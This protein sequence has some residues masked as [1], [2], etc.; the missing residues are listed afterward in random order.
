MFEF[1]PGWGWLFLAYTVGTLFGLWYTKKGT[2]EKTIDSLIA[3]GY[4]KHRRKADGEI[5]ILKYNEE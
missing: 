1:A 3:N 4:L 5:E 2:I